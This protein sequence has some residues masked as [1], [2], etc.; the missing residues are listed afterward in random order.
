MAVQRQLGDLLPG[1]LMLGPGFLVSEPSCASEAMHLSGTSAS[2]WATS[3]IRHPEAIRG[4]KISEGASEEAMLIQKGWKRSLLIAAFCS[5][6]V[7]C[8]KDLCKT[9]SRV[10][11]RRLRLRARRKR[12]LPPQRKQEL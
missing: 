12:E 4:Q 1:D 5:T 9:R 2:T 10:V 8:G 3:A 7:C 11:Q 6:H